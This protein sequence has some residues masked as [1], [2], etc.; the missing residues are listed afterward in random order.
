[1]LPAVGGFKKEKDMF[2]P[3]LGVKHH[4]NLTDFCIFFCSDGL[5]KN[6]QLMIFFD[7]FEVL[8]LATKAPK[9]LVICLQAMELICRHLLAIAGGFGSVLAAHFLPRR[10]G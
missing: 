8:G 7:H 1:M 4:C 10:V 5:V 6:Q 2:I 9:K 3:K